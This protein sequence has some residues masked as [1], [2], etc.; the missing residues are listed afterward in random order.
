MPAIDRQDLPRGV[1]KNTYSLD[2]NRP[3]VIP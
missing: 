2:I 3:T 1:D